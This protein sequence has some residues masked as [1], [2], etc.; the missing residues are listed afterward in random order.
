MQFIN[1]YK[2]LKKELYILFIGRVVTAMGAVVH[3]LLVLMLR[4]KLGFS[5]SEITL[6]M[7]IFT[8]SALPANIIGGKLTD[9]FGRKRLIVIFDLITISLFFVASLLPIS[10]TTIILI[11][12]GGLFAQAEQPAYDALIA[13]FSLPKDREKAYS[14]GYLGWN[15]G[16]V[17]GPTLGGF[18]FENMLNL[19][20][21]ISGI[22]TLVST[23]L[24]FLFIHDRNSYRGK[25]IDEELKNKYEEVDEKA[26]TTSVI[27][28]RKLVLFYVLLCAIG[29][30]VYGIVGLILPLNLETVFAAKGAVYY[31]ILSSFNGLVVILFTPIVTIK[32]QKVFE[33]NKTRLGYFL[34]AASLLFFMFG[35]TAIWLLF[36]GMFFF[37]IGE[38]MSA[39]A[40]A[41]YITRRIPSSHRGRMFA[42]LAIIN[43]VIA[44]IAQFIIGQVL[45]V[46]SYQVVWIIFI[47]IGLLNTL[48]FRLLIAKDKV[49]FPDLYQ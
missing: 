22:S 28:D 17:V 5:P 10:I 49:K 20:F 40:R 32:T 30:V 7:I 16:F 2:G 38:I 45:E 48:L 46:A 24:V 26:S 21:F 23:V 37:T 25:V 4:R 42:I 31:G 39:I 8:L 47:S 41:P 43:T 14:L 18:L 36:F 13:D 15:L 19:A 1:Q 27:K 6:V 9:R 33:L 3:P 34:I 29:S 12:I 35:T 11:G 44:V